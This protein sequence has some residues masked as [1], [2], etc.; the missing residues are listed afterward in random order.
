MTKQME[1]FK[2]YL[3]DF[4]AKH[5]NDIKKNPEFRAQFQEMCASVGVDPLACKLH[6]PVKRYLFYFWHKYYMSSVR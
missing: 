2:G 5:K 1:T 3:E 6:Y 4:A